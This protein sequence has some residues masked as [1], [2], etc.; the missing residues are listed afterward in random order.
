MTWRMGMESNEVSKVR[1]DIVEYTRGF[2]LDI[3]CGPHKG[4]PHF[5]G[6]DN[7]KDSRLFGIHMDPDVTRDA[8][9]LG[10]YK[11][12]GCD[13]VFSSHCLEHLVSTERTWITSTTSC[14]PTS[15]SPC[16]IW[17]AGICW[18]TRSGTGKTNTHFSKCSGSE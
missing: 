5:V 3:G 9:D 6:V 8:M 1:W 11:D 10:P 18:S 4:F 2:G 7:M 12:G 17:V 15:L 14:L 16:G 13:F